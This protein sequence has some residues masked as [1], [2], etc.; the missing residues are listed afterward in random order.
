VCVRAKT[1]PEILAHNVAA[2]PGDAAVTDSRGTLS[3]LELAELSEGYAAL[4]ASQGAGLGSSVAL[5]L[6]NSADYLA[7]IFACARLGALAV[8]I[9]TRFRTAEAAYLLRRSQATA[10]V[11]A[12]GFEPV[13]FP[14][15][16]AAIPVE[17]RRALQCVVGRDATAG[18]AA[19]LPVTRLEPRG[20]IADAATPEA[21]CLTFTTSGTT[22]GPKLVL[23]RQ[24]SIAGH[25]T[26]V[27]VALGTGSA[28]S[29][30]LSAIPLCG[31]FGLALA[32]GAAAGGA[33]IVLM[34]Q[35]DGEAAGNLIR[36]HA[37]THTAGSDDMLGRIAEA[38]QGR[39]FE[40]LAFSGY[41]TFTPRAEKMV[42][43][44]DAAGMKPR[45]LY[46][47]SEVQALFAI[48]PDS[49]RLKDGGV[50]VSPD[51][52]FSVRDPETGAQLP[53]GQD[54]ELCLRAPSCFD[55]YLGD[56]E[57]TGRALTA[58]G[59]FRTGDLAASAAPGFV[60]KSRIGDSL[61]LGGFLV[62]PEEIEAFLQTLPGVGEAQVVA[63][64]A[65]G[66]RAAVAF[67]RPAPNAI[68]DEDAILAACRDSLARY[69]QPARAIVIE[70][71]PVTDSPNGVKIQRA[72]LREI[73]NA[74]LRTGA[75]QKSSFP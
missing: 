5:W 7:L 23:H 9:N 45:G 15:L 13:N 3:W 66:E 31:T 63:A 12:W 22:S 19:G 33:H 64:E 8:H 69:K 17:D 58:D 11:T 10:V 21:P 57:A 18:V 29:C 20:R 55:G 37:V 47:S 6:P 2:R 50:P 68:P 34:P 72:K 48:S 32:M 16:L 73:A 38:A 54:G 70:A 56:P 39:S 60:Y 59:L 43:A 27:S 53:E 42:A 25:A 51:A 74:A 41:A 75:F 35:F 52:Q 61:R 28:G 30:V 24:R 71:F 67:I 65:D 26:D 49:R 62:N 4:L 14:E 36:K 40:T 44:A 46:G 1:L